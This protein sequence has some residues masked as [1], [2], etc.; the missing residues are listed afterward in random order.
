MVEF[1]QRGCFGGIHIF[2]RHLSCIGLHYSIISI[3][4]ILFVVFC[5]VFRVGELLLLKGARVPECKLEVK[6]GW[7]LCASWF[8]Q[9]FD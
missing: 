9:C 5:A 7:P 8:G 6:I 3:H 2:C 4:D 1:I